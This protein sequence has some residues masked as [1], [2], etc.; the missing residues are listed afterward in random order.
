[1]SFLHFIQPLRNVTTNLKV[2]CLKADYI[3]RYIIFKFYLSQ[4]TKHTT[5]TGAAK[6]QIRLL[7]QEIQ[8]LGK[9]GREKKNINSEIA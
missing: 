6:V 3:V 1:M 4:R 2:L 9:R 7:V 5:K 8:Q